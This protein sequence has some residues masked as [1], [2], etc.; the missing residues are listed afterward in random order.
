[1]VPSAERSTVLSPY[2]TPLAVRS[3]SCSP[4][5]I[6]LSLRHISSGTHRPHFCL[7]TSVDGVVNLHGVGFL[8]LRRA[9]VGEERYTR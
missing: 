4:L 7:R 1:M 2:R 3:P 8:L 5:P 9:A 6:V